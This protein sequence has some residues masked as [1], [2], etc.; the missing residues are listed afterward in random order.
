MHDVRGARERRAIDVRHRMAVRRDDEFEQGGR[1]D[2]HG[3][4]LAVGAGD[5]PQD[6]SA[7]ALAG[8][9]AHAIDLD[10]RLAERAVGRRA[11]GESGHQP[12]ERHLR[13]GCDI[14][15][16]GLAAGDEL[17]DLAEGAR[18]ERDLA[19]IELAEHQIGRAAQRRALA[20]DAGRRAGAADEAAVRLR[21]LVVAVAAQGQECGARHDVALAA[22]EALEERRAAVELAARIVLPVE[23][24][25]VRHAAQHRMADARGAAARDQVADRVAAAR[26]ADQRD[27]RRAGARER[28]IDRGS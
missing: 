23:H 1:V 6:R 5:V 3:S 17:V 13:L 8:L 4:P 10:R 19:M 14:E 2:R 24:A 7:D 15:P 16:P 25:A 27:P 9:R 28:G 11:A 18:V 12:V 20:G 21:E 22:I 26:G